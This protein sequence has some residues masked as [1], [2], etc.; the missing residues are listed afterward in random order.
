M[1]DTASVQRDERGDWRPADPIALA[2]INNWP[3]NPKAIT[4]W[5]FGWPGYLWPYNAFWLLVAVVTWVFLTPSLQAMQSIEAWWVGLLLSR[6]V[7]FILL[8]FGG[9]H[10]YLY[11]L[12]AQGEECRY[13][14]RSFAV[15]SRRFRFNHQVWDNMFHTLVSGVPVFTAYEVITYW[16]FANGFLGYGSGG[17]ASVGFWI[18]AVVLL[19]LAPVIHS[20]HFYFGHRLLHTKLLYR[21]FHALHHHNVDVGPWSGLSMHPV[22]HI[23]YFSTV[24]VQWLLALHPI[25]ALYQIQLAAFLPALSHSGFEKVT[26]GKTFSLDGGSHFHYLHHKLFECNYGG[27]LLPLDRLFGTFHDGT[28][29]ADA[30][31]RERIR[32]R[33]QALREAK[34][35]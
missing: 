14:T 2:P 7:G 13:T 22:E 1:T 27:S 25:N 4:Q 28:V 23:V 17:S 33:R 3:P 18:W 10:L 29:E 34:A 20:L 26:M 9:L 30:A 15:G 8:L 24:V 35:A 5:L 19:L 12:R 11:V 21:R 32:A 16:G 31:M 6:N